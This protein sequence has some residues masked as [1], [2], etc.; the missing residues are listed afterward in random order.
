MVERQ[1]LKQVERKGFK[2]GFKVYHQ[3]KTKNG[4]IKQRI[5]Q[6]GIKLVLWREVTSPRGGLATECWLTKS[7]LEG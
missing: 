2:K 4:S 1:G 3:V 7:V 5:L 6:F